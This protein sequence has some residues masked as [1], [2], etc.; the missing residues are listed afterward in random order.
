MITRLCTFTNQAALRPMEIN[1]DFNVQLWA[2][3]FGGIQCLH[4]FTTGLIVLQIERNQIDPAFGL[5][6]QLKNT[7]FEL[8]GLMQ[9]L[10]GVTVHW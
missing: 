1:K 10:H 4:D 2:G 9:D 7:L 3:L 8:T 5:S 6:N